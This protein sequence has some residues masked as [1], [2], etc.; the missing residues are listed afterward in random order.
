[1]QVAGDFRLGE[2]DSAGSGIYV[3]LT[4]PLGR[5]AATWGCVG[6]ALLGLVG[7]FLLGSELD[8]RRLL[9]WGA[10]VIV[11]AWLPLG[12]CLLLGRLLRSARLARGATETTFCRFDAD[13]EGLRASLDGVTHA[14]AWP[15]ITEIMRYRD[16]W[17]FAGATSLC[18]PRRWFADAAAE[19]AFLKH[20]LSHLSPEALARSRDAT[21]VC[22]GKAAPW[23]SYGHGAAA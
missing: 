7:F 8:D 14:I 15:R 16:L 22:S 12:I 21:F 13:D 18:L 1:M 19:A 5:L 2:T 3:H 23:A 9:I 20:A 17:I 11:F 4:G 6:P 10:L